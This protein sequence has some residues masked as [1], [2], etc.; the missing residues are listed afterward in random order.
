VDP[1][2]GAQQFEARRL[3]EPKLG[4][5]VARLIREPARDWPPQ[6][7][8]RA[9]LLA[10]ALVQNP[11]LALMRAQLRAAQA[12]QITAGEIVNPDLTLQSEYARHDAHPWLYGMSLNWLLRSTERRRLELEIARLDASA[13]NFELMEQSWALRRDLAAAMSAWEGARRRLA[14]LDSLAQSQDRLLALETQRVAAGED[15]PS[16][17]LLAHQSRQEIE[18]Q[19]GEL[20]AAGD[21]AQVAAAQILGLLPQ[22]LDGVNIEWPDWGEPPAVDDR[23]Q[24]ELREQALLSRADLEVAIRGY[25]VAESKLKQAVARQYPQL[26][27]GPGYYWD[28]GIAKFPFDVGFTLPLNRNRGEIAE[29]RAA[30]DVAGQRLLALQTDI[31]GAIAAA[32]RAESLARVRVDAAEQQYISAGRQAGL[33]QL[34]V[35]LGASGSQERIGYEIIAAKAQLEVVRMRAELQAARNALED[36]L[37]APLSGPELAMAQLWS[38]TSA[39]AGS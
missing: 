2:R 19:R 30:R 17:L 31:D 38:S 27:L 39:G 20:R 9:Q 12:H 33:A 35:R 11:Q 18:Q 10:V 37:H 13:A 16:E 24:R 3:D 26:T 29:A 28:H 5:A 32:Q 1:V 7:F 36:V 21:A 14:L 6:K 34:G 25:A 4:E 8:N 23:R 15:A 22:A